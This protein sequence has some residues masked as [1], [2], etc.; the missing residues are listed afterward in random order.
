MRSGVARRLQK[1]L[2]RKHVDFLDR[3][4]DIEHVLA[5]G[6]DQLVVKDV[7]VADAIEDFEHGCRLRKPIFTSLQRGAP[8]KGS[9]HRE[10]PGM[11]G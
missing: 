7:S 11:F 1:A 9:G 4:R 2:G 8:A 3:G 5:F 10:G 6:H